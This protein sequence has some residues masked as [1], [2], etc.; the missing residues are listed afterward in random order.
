MLSD[1]RRYQSLFFLLYASIN[2]IAGYR[3]VFFADIGLTESQMGVIGAVLVGAGILA[4]PF[5]GVFADTLGRTKLLMAAGAVV[6]VAGGLLFPIG[7]VVESPFFLML[8]AAVIY[9]AFRS[10]IVPL[11]NSMVMSSGI[12]YGSVRAFGSIA[13]GIGILAMGPLVNS[14]GTVTIFAIY[15]VG[16]AGFVLSLRGLPRPPSAELSPDLRTDALGLLTN[17]RFVL[18]L[19]VAFLF[20]ASTSTGNA[21]FSVYIRAIEASDTMTGVAWFLRTL[22]E[23]AVFI[24]AVRLDLDHRSQLLVGTLVCAVS[25]LLYVTPGTLPVVFLAQVPLGAGF[26]FYTL[27]SVSLAHEYAPATLSASAQ[28][29]LAALGLGTGR[30][31]GQAVGG[32]IAEITS[33]QALYLYLALAALL[34][35][36][37]SL[38]FF[39]R[40]VETRIR[41]AWR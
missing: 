32:W 35:A 29:V 16:M 27:A 39:T 1:E 2:G 14:F 12:D 3:N 18:L 30:V 7:M 25:F 11:A 28:A 17:P 40:S 33:V 37:F 34:A 36:L 22:A 24:W 6:S 4:Q 23:A 38:G 21:F 10:P 8:L 31:L 15:A 5:W 13:F 26:A 9:S 19:G 20:G 41:A